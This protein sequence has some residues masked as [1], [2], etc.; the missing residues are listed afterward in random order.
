MIT[1][2][3]INININEKYNLPDKY[4]MSLSTL[5]P[6][7]N[8]V[9]LLNSFAGVM[10]KVDYDLVLVGRTGWKMDEV[11][12]K[13]NSMSR[14][15]LTG[16]VKDSDVALIYK[17][18]LCFVFPTLYEGF[19]LPPIEALALGTPVISSD[20]A[21]MKEILM[22]QAVYFKS[23][24]ENELKSLLLNLEKNM[25]TMPRALNEYQKKNYNFKISA[26]KILKILKK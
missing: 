19:G 16:F 5:E 3:D 15:H 26:K 8:L 1:N 7:K 24:N 13:Y 9:L 10:D 21:S 12:K 23:G 17:N 14:I 25:S 11:V 18:T 4:I 22:E 6:R 20:A 2:S